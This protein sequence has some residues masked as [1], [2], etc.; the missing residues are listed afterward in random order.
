M[1]FKVG[2]ATYRFI[3]HN[4]TTRRNIRLAITYGVLIL[5]WRVLWLPIAH[6]DGGSIPNLSQR[7]IVDNLTLP[8]YCQSNSMSFYQIY[9]KLNARYSKSPC[10]EFPFP[11]HRCRWCWPQR[12]SER[13]PRRHFDLRPRLPPHQ[14]QSKAQILTQ[15]TITAYGK[16]ISNQKIRRKEMILRLYYVFRLRWTCTNPDPGQSAVPHIPRIKE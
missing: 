4:D 7:N 15:F 11:Q 10:Q 12:R 13:I 5:I 8:L 6:Q 14:N 9:R 2:A 3:L 16:I 1:L